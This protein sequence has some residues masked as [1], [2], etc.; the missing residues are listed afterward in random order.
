MTTTSKY[1]SAKLPLDACQYDVH[2]VLERACC[3][4]QTQR[5]YRN[6]YCRWGDVTVNFFLSRSSILISQYL[7]L[8]S[9]LEYMRSA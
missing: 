6:L 1:M 3:V 4:I 8:S 2:L 5:Y 7:Q 9:Y